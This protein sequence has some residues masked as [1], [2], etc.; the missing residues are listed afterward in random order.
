MKL[1][2]AM[3]YTVNL[4]SGY[5]CRSGWRKKIEDKSEDSPMGSIV[6]IFGHPLLREERV[7]LHN[8]SACRV[9]QQDLTQ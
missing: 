1:F 4:I 6:T 5:S 8:S 2:L 3:D 9:V 7:F